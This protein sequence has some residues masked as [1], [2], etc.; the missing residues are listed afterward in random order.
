[1]VNYSKGKERVITIGIPLITAILL[2]LLDV[3]GKSYLTPILLVGL[4]VFLSLAILYFAIRFLEDRE[5]RWK[6]N[7][8]SHD[9]FR[10]RLDKLESSLKDFLVQQKT[11]EKINKLENRISYLEGRTKK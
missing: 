7:K 6:G 3:F 1:M 5:L 8:S 9:D 11:H 2:G 4:G 10:A